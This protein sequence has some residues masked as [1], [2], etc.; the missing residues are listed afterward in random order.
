MTHE[1]TEQERIQ[2][3]AALRDQKA[4]DHLSQ[5]APVWKVSEKPI[6]DEDS[7]LFEVVFLHPHYSWVKR[8]YYYDA[9]QDV[10]YHKGQITVSEDEA[11]EIQQ[12]EPYIKTSIYNMVNSYGG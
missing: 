5:Y 7:V 9:F 1:V 12:Q 3:I 4:Q 10:L 6:P 8:R 2:K 11:A